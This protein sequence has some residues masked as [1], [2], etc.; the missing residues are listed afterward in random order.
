MNFYNQIN[1]LKSI[2][3]TIKDSEIFLQKKLGQ[4]FIFDLNLTNKI[5]LNSKCK[6]KNIVE[7]GPGVGSLTRSL[8]LNGAKHIFAVEK[9]INS[10]NA[11]S[12]LK[13][14][15][16]T[17]L[18]L[19]HEDAK[20]IKLHS[21]YSSPFTVVGNLPYNIATFL[22]ISWIKEIHEYQLTNSMLVERIVILVQEEVAKKISANV[23]E[24]LYGRLSVFI[25]LFCNCKIK[26][27]LNP[28]CFFPAPKVNSSLI[29]IIPLKRMR[30]KVNLNLFEEI[31][32]ICFS[33]R[34][35]MIRHSLKKL[36][37]NTII[38]SANINGSHRPENLTT[39]DFCNLAN[40]LEK[41]NISY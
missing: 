13:S 14:I 37:G 9:D 30:H 34:R 39:K 12:E 1:K 2:Q 26:I 5:A 10:I 22:I 27:N 4:N 38:S 40:A 41:I 31:T 3:K 19:I 16:K 11:L 6:N 21:L 20:K 24:K 23:G 28:N 29:E 8:F 33:Q 35:K 15:A 36:H 7:I 18:D 32:R 17:K 25:D